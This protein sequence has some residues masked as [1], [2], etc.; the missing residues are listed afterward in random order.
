LQELQALLPKAA[1]Q[2]VNLPLL[3][4]KLSADL[5]AAL[6]YYLAIRYKIEVNK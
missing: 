3:A 2:S 6:E 5:L 1:R 4:D